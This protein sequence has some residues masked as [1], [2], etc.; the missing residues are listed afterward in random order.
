MNY[1]REYLI[2]APKV[3]RTHCYVQTPTKYDIVCPICGKT[4]TAW[5]EF[6]KHIWCY[7]CK[8]DVYVPVNE[9]G[10]FS[11]PIPWGVCH[12]IFGLTFARF[13]LVT[14]KIE[15]VIEDDGGEWTQEHNDLFNASFVNDAALNEYESLEKDNRIEGD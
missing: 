6:E 3:K 1:K 11:G 4:N 13:S 12:R 9:S 8:E 2:G 10:I 14:E 15:D 7:D 5:S